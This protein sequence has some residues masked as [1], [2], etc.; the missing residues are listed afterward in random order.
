MSWTA[1]VQDPLLLI[2][3]LSV[4]VVVS[5]VLFFPL[6]ADDFLL[7]DVARHH[8]VPDLLSGRH[9]IWPWYRPLSR[10]LFFWILAQTGSLA[11]LVAHVFTAGAATIAGLLIYRI[12][13][14]TA[15]SLAGAI[16]AMLF[17]TY[18][19]TKFLAAWASGF[20]DLL[21]LLLTLSAV[22]ALQSTRPRAAL[23]LAAL[24]P[25]AKEAAFVVYPIL[26][27]QSLLLRSGSVQALKVR[28]VLLSALVPVLLHVAARSTWPNLEMPQTTAPDTT[29]LPAVLW[30][31]VSFF[32]GGGAA[33]TAR[34]V[35]L[36][37]FAAGLAW[38][39]VRRATAQDSPAPARL[40]RVVSWFATGAALG[41]L[42]VVIAHSLHLTYAHAYHLIPAI[43]WCCMLLGVAI[44]R[45]PTTVVRIGVPALVLWCTVG[46]SRAPVDLDQPESWQTTPFGWQDALRYVAVTERLGSD[47]RSLLA[48]RPESLVVLFEN[49]PLRTFLQTADGPALR[50]LLGDDS[51]QSFWSSEAPWLSEHR[52]VRVL[53]FDF[54][55]LHLRQANWS[56]NEAL[57]RAS[58]A[59]IAGRGSIA[60]ATIRFAV[61]EGEAEP[62]RSHLLAAAV[63]VDHGV[64]AYVERLRAMGLID[65]LAPRLAMV[66]GVMTDGD[67]GLAPVQLEALRHP[68]TAIAY[69]ALSEAFAA[70]GLV[71]GAAFHL[72]VAISLRPD[73]WPERL[74]LAQLMLELGGGKEAKEELS[75]IASSTSSGTAGE[76]AREWMHAL[77]ATTT[78]SLRAP[79]LP[80]SP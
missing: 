1:R 64:L 47:M 59:I 72:R 33:P 74:R 43:P 8:S 42:P 12:V 3:G 77:E 46:L 5:D 39:L 73:L 66:A 58:N 37:A 29:R 18:E 34:G 55:A 16:A 71:Q 68:L 56:T 4:L 52:V 78:G 10:E 53:A 15:S 48:D 75:A 28:G 63:L 51:V 35:M 80:A 44:A 69:V 50:E 6:F 38:L 67:P 40:K 21:A 61:A 24:A 32:G 20:Q 22:L 7:M 62:A 13:A 25:L 31:A 49:L 65:S 26:V 60:A 9:G 76:R 54:D 2:T 57:D 79:P 11:P 27:S 19:A 36:A 70:R 14:N 41:I 45:F 30:H 23:V 17:L